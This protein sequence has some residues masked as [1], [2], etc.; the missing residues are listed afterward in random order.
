MGGCHV[1]ISKLPSYHLSKDLNTS[2]T[3]NPNKALEIGGCKLSNLRLIQDVHIII[4]LSCNHVKGC[5]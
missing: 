3:Q 2:M 1:L 4:T 5:C